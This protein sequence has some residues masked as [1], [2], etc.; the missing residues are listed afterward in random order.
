MYNSTFLLGDWL[1][2]QINVNI[3]GSAI[4]TSLLILGIIALFMVITQQSIYATV[5][6]LFIAGMG[7]L[8]GYGLELKAI[9]IIILIAVILIVYVFK[10]FIDR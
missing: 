6:V 7:L 2:N 4:I 10:W 3:T 5:A 1:F 9:G 8:Y